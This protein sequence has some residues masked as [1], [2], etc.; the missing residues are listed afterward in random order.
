MDAK[1]VDLMGRW[2]KSWAFYIN[3]E[4]KFKPHENIKYNA[5][6]IVTVCFGYTVGS[7][8]GGNRPSVVVEDNDHSDKTIMVIP[9][10][11]LEPGETIHAKNVY[12][13][14]LVDYNAATGKP[15]GTES[16]ALTHQMRAVSKQRIIRPVAETDT[17]ITLD[18]ADLQ[19]VYDKI[20]ELYAPTNANVGQ[21]TTVVQV[22][23]SEVASSE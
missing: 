14:E 11:S 7:E 20:R 23:D 9:L 16:V 8:Q 4:K 22:A 18:P 5:G 1:H 2:L 3:R 15:A 12:L 13:G 10:S 6:D 21:A 17:V 19:K